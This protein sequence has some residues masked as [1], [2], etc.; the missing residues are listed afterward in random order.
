MRKITL[1]IFAFI[2]IA[3]T[4]FGQSPEGFKYQSV[5]R[6]ATNAIIVNQAVGMQLTILQTS[7]TGTAVYTETFSTT[8][9]AFGLVNLEIGTGT[10]TDDFS[11]ID[12]ANGPYFIETAIDVAGG[13]SY[14]VMGTSQLM[15]VPYALHSK[16]SGDAFSGNYNDLT[17]APVN[18]SSFTNDAAYITSPDDAD[19]NPLNEMNVSVVL[20]GTNLETTD[21]GGT[22]VTDLSSL[23]TGGVAN[24]TLGG[25][26]IFNNNTGSVVVGTNLTNSNVNFAVTNNMSPKASIGNQGAFNNANSG[27]LLFAEDANYASE[28]GIKFQ[29]NGA[30]NN[31]YLIGG[32]SAPD[33]IVRFNRSGYSNIK[34]LKIGANYNTNAGIQFEVDG[35]SGFN[36]SVTITGDLNVTGNI[37]KGGG[38]FKIDH[39]LD[40]ENKYLIH[41][42]VESPEMMN[43]FSGNITTDENGMAIVQ[44]PDY[45]EA[46]NED[47]RYQLTVIGTFAQ[48]IIKEKIKGNV[49][50]I[51]TNQPNVEVSWAVTSVRADKYAVKNR[52]APVVEKEFKGSYIHPELYGFGKDKSES[53]ARSKFFELQNTKTSTSNFDGQ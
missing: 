41:S 37:A 20:N 27:E 11:A 43:I 2:A 39:P 51:Q 4:S 40:P 38:T 12:W 32:C 19:A 30:L 21:G 9:N 50:V 26:N 17:G 36:G 7:P 22:I 16:T 48:A 47:F 42:F 13:T 31:L 45:F 49:F 33:T 6:D 1:S 29:H 18:V 52:I 53:V 5:I 15:S 3:L 8:S 24:W 28:C 35:L 10:T 23:A 14:V 25:N 46:A 44:M 34:Q